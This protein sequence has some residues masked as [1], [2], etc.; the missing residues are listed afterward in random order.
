[1]SNQ[2]KLDGGRMTTFADRDVHL[3]WSGVRRAISQHVSIRTSIKQPL[4]VENPCNPSFG[5]H[6]LFECVL[7]TP[8]RVAYSRS[9]AEIG[10]MGVRHEPLD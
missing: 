9:T 10:R 5:E 1:M 8:L 6:D 2:L 7:L 4:V 3:G